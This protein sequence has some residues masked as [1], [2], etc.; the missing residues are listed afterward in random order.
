MTKKYVASH[1]DYLGQV[2]DTLE[3]AQRA[4]LGMDYESDAHTGYSSAFNCEPLHNG[5]V[6]EID[7]RKVTV[8]EYKQ[9]LKDMKK[10]EERL[11]REIAKLKE[12]Y[13]DKYEA[14]K[15]AYVNNN[16]PYNYGDK[17]R[18]TTIRK[19]GRKRVIEA[20][21]C[22]IL[23]ARDT[24]ELRPDLYGVH[25]PADEPIVSIEVLERKDYRTVRQRVVCQ[26]CKFWDGTR[27]EIGTCSKHNKQV[28]GLKVN[29]Y[30]CYENDPDKEVP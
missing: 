23:V 12:K 28:Y 25:Y 7:D 17:I 6:R 1:L 9:C 8:E 11:E 21:V 16:T 2:C 24:C 29:Q 15:Y 22:G 30:D 27:Y 10:A 26:N 13:L 4:A 18:L 5:R 19:S 3:D 20:K 14:I